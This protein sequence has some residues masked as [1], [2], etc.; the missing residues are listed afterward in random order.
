MTGSD[1]GP[2]QPQSAAQPDSDPVPDDDW[3]DDDWPDDEPGDPWP[4]G[5]HAQPGGPGGGPGPRKHPPWLPIAL[6]GVLAGA[7]GI[8]VALLVSGS[9]SAPSA[10][11]PTAGG[12][13]SV[14]APALGG[15]GS[16]LPSGLGH[17][18]LL[19][20]GR[21]SAVTSHSITLSAGGQTVTAAID[22]STRFT[23][24]VHDAT[25]IKVGDQAVAQITGHGSNLVVVTI[26]DPAQSP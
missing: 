26:Q 6:T 25:G 9:P 4:V 5:A 12:A 14:A 18:T 20:G 23:G 10:G 1:P 15:N 22:S 13:P 19:M 24:T 11:S 8:V 3:P 17:E 2:A 21:V 16:T 7:A